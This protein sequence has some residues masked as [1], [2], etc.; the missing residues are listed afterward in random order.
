MWPN[1]Y[2]GPKLTVNTQQNFPNWHMCVAR[3]V[4]CCQAAAAQAMATQVQR[5]GNRHSPGTSGSSHPEYAKQPRQFQ[6]QAILRHCPLS[7]SLCIPRAMKRS[8]LSY[9]VG[10]IPAQLSPHSSWLLENTH[11]P[12]FL[13]L[14][15]LF[16]YLPL[17]RHSSVK[18]PAAIMK[19][20]AGATASKS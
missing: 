1:D 9:P 17:R 3:W 15:L 12:S 18:L 4:A 5:H 20:V 8:S 10:K 16:S 2:L 19:F 6:T 13:L 14:P 7:L 11:P